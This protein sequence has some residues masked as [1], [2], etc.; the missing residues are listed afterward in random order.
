MAR[1]TESIIQ[2]KK[3]CYITGSIADLHSHHIFE[4]SCRKSSEKFGLKVWLRSDWHNLS[5]CGVHFNKGL[6]LEL[7]Q[8]AQ[9]KFEETHTREEFRRHFIKSYL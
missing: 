6:D 8:M 9:K 1:N 7:K 5:N 3:E 2:T 4:G